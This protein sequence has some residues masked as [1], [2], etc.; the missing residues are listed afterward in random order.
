LKNGEIG[1]AALDVT[2]DT[3]YSGPLSDLPNCILT[4][5]AGAATF[6]ASSKMSYLAAENI[7]AIL[8]GT[9]CKYCVE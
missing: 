9:H 2:V 1:S 6:E 3:P 8:D 7:L 5:H 4:P